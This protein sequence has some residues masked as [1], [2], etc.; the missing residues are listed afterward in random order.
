MGMPENYKTR[1]G[2]S[3]E[4]L[5]KKIY[6]SRGFEVI[7]ENFYNH[8]GKQAAEIDFIAARGRELHFVE[9]KTRSSDRYGNGLEAIGY[10]KQQRILRGA[11]IFLGRFP[12]FYGFTPHVDV[13]IVQMAAFDKTPPK[14][15][16]YSDAIGGNC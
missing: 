11:R 5:A 8:S 1:V 6:R 10:A 3:G 15:K 13:V 16:I 14:I 2:R 12:K 7:A 9:V 4:L